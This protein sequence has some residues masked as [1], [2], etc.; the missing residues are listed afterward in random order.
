MSRGFPLEAP[1]R[2][3]VDAARVMESLA[4]ESHG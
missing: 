3:A 2:L 1:A 4:I